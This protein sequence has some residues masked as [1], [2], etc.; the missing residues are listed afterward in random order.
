MALK[1][2]IIGIRLF[3]LSFFWTLALSETN[4]FLFIFVNCLDFCL[5]S[6]NTLTKIAVFSSSYNFSSWL[7]VNTT[8]LIRCPVNA[9]SIEFSSFLSIHLKFCSVDQ[10][11]SS[12]F[13]LFQVFQFLFYAICASLGRLAF[14]FI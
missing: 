7:K 3:F 12:L 9:S 5:S 8:F 14:L 2:N 11:F 4:T 10:V 6:F 1:S 13:Q